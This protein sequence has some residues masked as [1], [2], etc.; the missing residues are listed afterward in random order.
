MDGSLL[1]VVA[2]NIH[3]S[4]YNPA[5]GEEAVTRTMLTGRRRSRSHHTA[6]LASQGDVA[7][8]ITGSHMTRHSHIDHSLGKNEAK[9]RKGDD[10]KGGRLA[11]I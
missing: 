3:Q 10:I 11:I 8:K 1:L 2:K 6:K 9:R 7:N 4:I 5:Q